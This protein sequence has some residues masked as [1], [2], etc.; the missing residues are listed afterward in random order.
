MIIGA[1]GIGSLL[2]VSPAS[3]ASAG[4]T[5]ARV[6]GI[7]SSKKNFAETFYT[8]VTFRSIRLL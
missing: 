5:G 4:D 2:I 8:K 3:S 6:S 7:F 1:T